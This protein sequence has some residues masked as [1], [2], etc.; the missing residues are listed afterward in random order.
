MIKSLGKKI[1][2]IMLALVSVLCIGASAIVSANANTFDITTVSFTMVEGASVRISGTVA[3]G[4]RFTAKMGKTEYEDIVK[5]TGEE[6]TYSAVEFGVLI[7]PKDYAETTGYEITK[8]NVFGASAVY[9][10]NVEASSLVGTNK[11]AIIRTSTSELTWS[12]KEN[13]YVFGGSI[14]DLLS[15]NLTREFIGTPYIGYKQA[16]A[17]EYEYMLGGYYKGDALNNTRSM[18]YVAQKAL[19]EETNAKIIASLTD[20]YITPVVSQN[21]NTTYNVKRHFA[22]GYGNYVYDAYYSNDDVYVEGKQLGT[23]TAKVGQKLNFNEYDVEYLMDAYTLNQE[24]S[25]VTPTVLAN[26]KL[27]VN[28]YYDLDL[29]GDAVHGFFSIYDG[30]AENLSDNDLDTFVW[31]GSYATNSA[32]MVADLGEITTV[33]DIEI[34]MNR[35]GDRWAGA[36]VEY[37]VDGKTFI[38]VDGKIDDGVTTTVVDL[39]APVQA[40]YIRIKKDNSGG[41][42]IY[43]NEIMVNSK[44]QSLVIKDNAKMYVDSSTT[45]GVIPATAS[46]DL[47]NADGSYTSLDNASITTNFVAKPGLQTVT[48]TYDDGLGTVVT[49]TKTYEVW[50]QIKTAT[51]WQ[52]MNTY[53]DGYFVLANDITLE[54]GIADMIGQAPVN[55]DENGA[56]LYI[57]QTGVG[58]EPGVDTP[59]GINCAQKGISFTGK[60]DGAGYVISGF[61]APYTGVTS[62]YTWGRSMFPIIAEG[63]YVGNFT[64]KGATVNTGAYSGFISCL[65]MGT[66]E[67][68]AI[69]SDCSL[70][71]NRWAAGTVCAYNSGT[72]KNV[73]SNVTTFYQAIDVNNVRNFER[74]VFDVDQTGTVTN[75]FIGIEDYSSSLPIYTSENQEGWFYVKDFGMH[76]ANSSMCM[77]LGVSKTTVK[78]GEAFEI[79]YADP[80][81]MAGE[82]YVHTW[83]GGSRAVSFQATKNE[84]TFSMTITDDTIIAGSSYTLGIKVVGAR[85]S[86]YYTFTLTV[87]EE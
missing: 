78:V 22:D 74:A 9:A 35:A 37:S 59:H 17:S 20:N 52:L 8:D 87:V 14:T 86:L 7:V 64:L 16:G 70:Y 32:F 23:L 45:D 85:E 61:E 49:G 34:V 50:Y 12:E 2:L 11:K 27:E 75:T 66:I 82:F 77:I 18:T 83:T 73:V 15:T 71:T 43:V 13:G 80:T 57:D 58:M 10:H 72:I 47:L 62:A 41:A 30:D 26:G 42:W 67:N 25:D 31:T 56:N 39:D 68:I 76:Y 28:L 6:K 69:A 48:Y 63:A 54:G 44:P 84:H 79:Y 36:S 33:N 81:N 53:L 51:E 5:N 3:N 19:E 38:A 60:F 4:M 46:F 1:V 21:I 24:I 40:R 65:N 55:C 29:N